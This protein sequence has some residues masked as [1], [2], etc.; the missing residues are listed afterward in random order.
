MSPPRDPRRCYIC[1]HDVPRWASRLA[2]SLLM[3]AIA[4]SLLALS[5]AANKL[6]EVLPDSPLFGQDAGIL[7]GSLLCFFVVAPGI[8]WLSQ[9][10]CRV[11]DWVAVRLAA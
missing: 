5:W 10:I 6:D 3:L 7:F 11:I 2:M 4:S 8:H 9:R 1:G